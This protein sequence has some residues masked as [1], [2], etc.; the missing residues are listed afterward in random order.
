MKKFFQSIAYSIRENS[1]ELACLGIILWFVLSVIVGYLSSEV[2][3]NQHAP[4]EAAYQEYETIISQ[5]VDGEIENINIPEDTSFDIKDGEIEI[6]NDRGYYFVT[7][8]Y[9]GEELNFQRDDNE[10]E[11]MAFK[12]LVGGILVGV[13]FI[14]FFGGLILCGVIWVLSKLKE[15]VK[16]M[17]TDYK[18]QKNQIEAQ[19]I[20]EQKIKEN[21]ESKSEK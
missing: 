7:A 13:I 9:M 20:E 1:E 4:S 17:V 6:S 11:R 10:D 3:L 16:D 19:L 21:S 12:I 8:E 5:I 2:Y 15:L 14:G 18:W